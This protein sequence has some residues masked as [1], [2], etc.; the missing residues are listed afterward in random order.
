M[1]LN[2]SFSPE[3]YH[4]DCSNSMSDD[5][6]SR[7]TFQELKAHLF[8]DLNLISKKSSFCEPTVDRKKLKTFI[9]RLKSK[10][11]NKIYNCD[12]TT[13]E[14]FLMHQ[15]CMAFYKYN[16]FY[17]NMTHEEFRSKILYPNLVYMLFR[18]FPTL[19]GF[20]QSIINK[21]FNE[22]KFRSRSL[23]E[24]YVS[25]YYMDEHIIKSDVLYTFLGNQLRKLN[26]LTVKNLNN[27]YKSVF[28]NIFYYHFKSEQK[29]HSRYSDLSEM[30]TII[31]NDINMP[32]RLM[33]YRDVLY[34]LQVEKFC[35]RSP[36]LYQISYNFNIFRNV[37]IDN[38]FQNMYL[39]IE[40]DTFV[41]NNNQYKLMNI[42]D[43]DILSEDIIHQ[44]KQIP[45]IYKLLKSVKIINP[46]T[47]P[48][49]EMKIRPDNVKS[50]VL[51]ELHHSFK[52]VF[53][54][55]Y[56]YSILDKIAD[57]FINNILQGEYINLMTLSEVRIDEPTFIPQL[58][59]FVNI[60]IENSNASR[61]KNGRRDN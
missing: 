38:E 26:P 23:I 3:L 7:I 39:S 35:D 32:V 5:F 17:L 6:D 61:I 56:L 54:D 53:S 21:V 2:T 55:S 58:K 8:T 10:H 41:L 13:K 4:R 25:S 31:S 49:N 28:H 18:F 27:F 12:Q 22:I 48:Y 57:N 36:T 9:E 40:K 34:N 15:I 16:D 19:R 47:T 52:N 30:E 42:Y 24:K 14:M 45:S 33:L 1:L 37:I 20:L 11:Y 29:I 43:N 51:E 59:K 44:I 46:K 50:A 60:C